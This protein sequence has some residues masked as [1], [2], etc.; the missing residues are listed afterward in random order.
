[1]VYIIF[2]IIV[3]SPYLFTKLRIV[4]SR[5]NYLSSES[6]VPKRY[7]NYYFVIVSLYMILLLGLRHDYVGTDTQN[8]RWTYD[9]FRSLTF[10]TALKYNSDFGFT[11]V[12]QKLASFGFDFRIVLFLQSI[13]YISSVTILIKN[14]SKNPVM[15][16]F[17]FMTLGYFIFATTMRQAIALSFTLLAYNSVKKKRLL[18]YLLYVSIAA[19]FH[20]SALI[21]LPAYW[22]DKFKFNKFTISI[23]S[24]IMV[25]T[26]CF[27]E[28]IGAF[29]LTYSKNDYSKT[30]TGGYFFILFIALMLI[31]GIIYRKNFIIKDTNNKMIFFMIAAT[32]ILLPISKLNPA[33]FRI[34]KY[35]D[36]FLILYVPNLI[37]SINDKGMKLTL[38]YGI[39]M[40]G[41]FYFYY[42][43]GSYGIRMHPYVFFWNEYPL[44]L[45]P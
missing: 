22:L 32:I 25:V 27:N 44:R 34:T 29:I 1:M 6:S 26:I 36:I 10:E 33:L 15:S 3:I 21:F 8:Y 2:F 39:I 31:L 5:Y 13:L 16:Y 35:Y 24:A 43:L 30:N 4:N 40:I 23:M 28:Q 37:S 18:I 17:L 20:L 38:T 42:S 19:T 7:S 14:Y 45:I 9:I 11:F 12:F 41:L